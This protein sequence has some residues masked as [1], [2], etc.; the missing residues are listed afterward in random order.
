MT[1]AESAKKRSV[2]LTPM[3]F[4]ATNTNQG[5]MLNQLDA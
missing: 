5:Y 2:K 3:N 4:D 1:K